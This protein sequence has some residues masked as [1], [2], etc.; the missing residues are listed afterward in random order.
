MALDLHRHARD[1]FGW[2]APWLLALPLLAGSIGFASRALRAVWWPESVLAEMSVH[3]ALNVGTAL[4]CILLVLLMHATLMT[5]AVARLVGQ[6]KRLARREGLTGLLNRRAMRRKAPPRRT[7]KTVGMVQQ[8]LTSRQPC[9]AAS[10]C[11]RRT[12]PGGMTAVW[13]R[14]STRSQSSE[15]STRAPA[16]TTSSS[17]SRSYFRPRPKNQ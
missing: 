1:A 10:S 3:S 17:T 9:F 14:T 11:Q 7:G 13:S 2:R 5:L 8:R 15:A 4:S 16:S 6:L 12:G